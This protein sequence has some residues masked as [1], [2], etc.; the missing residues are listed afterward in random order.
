MREDS[1]RVTGRRSHS[2]SAKEREVKWRETSIGEEWK[3]SV[4]RI[5]ASRI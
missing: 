3:K 4:L 1:S 5:L 2:V